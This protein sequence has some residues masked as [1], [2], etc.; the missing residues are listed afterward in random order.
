M[1]EPGGLSS[2]PLGGRLSDLSGR[3]SRSQR[4]WAMTAALV[5]GTVFLGM[6]FIQAPWQEK[7]REMGSRLEE[8]KQRSEL[9]LSIQRRRDAVRK[10]EAEILLE[11]GGAELTGEI[12]RMASEA[13]MAVESVLPYPDV[14]VAPYIQYE[15]EIVA[16]AS[17]EALLQFL[18]SIEAHRPL[19]MLSEM[20]IGTEAPTA[21]DEIL[22][23]QRIRT[24]IMAM[25][26]AER[27]Q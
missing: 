13:H 26:S 19:L 15:I 17:P 23:Q 25:G 9:L 2:L 14:E 5:L 8:E 20:E 22:D 3:M 16:T 12:S 27:P 18:R 6:T 11:G 1:K 10:N 4:F 7:R 21:T 24:K